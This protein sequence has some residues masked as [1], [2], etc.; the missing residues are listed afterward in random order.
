MPR[1]RAAQRAD[2]GTSDDAD[3]EE[4]ARLA[5]Y[6]DLDLQ[7]DPGDLDLYLALARRSGGPILELACGSGRLAVPLA[8]AGFVVTGLDNDRHMLTRARRRWEAAP[9]AAARSGGSLELVEG[10]LLEADLGGRFELV[11]LALNTLLLLGG[12]DAQAAAMRA[13]ARHLRPGGRGVV[14][15]WLP[16]PDDLALYDGRLLLEW[17]RADPGSG[18]RVAKISSASFDHA[19][20]MVELRSFFDAWPT[21]GGPVQRTARFDRL[22]LT[23][24]DELVRFASDAGLEVEELARDYALT[25]FGAGAERAV[26][27]GA[28]L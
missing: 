9:Q 24:A 7:G 14:D 6:Y 13:V 28:L 4:G 1:P 11:V 19:T 15:V 23:G 18:E 12:A 21:G 10:D 25:P 17:E 2:E 16:A 26:L 8:A 20:G 3:D 22:R 5:R 27:V